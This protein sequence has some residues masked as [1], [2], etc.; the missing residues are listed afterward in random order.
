MATR[1]LALAIS[2]LL[3]ACGGGGSDIAPA[4][5][6][7]PVQVAAYGDS[8]QRDQGEPHA[9]TR[10]GWSI[11]NKG[12]SS[13]TTAQWRAKWAAEMSTTAAVIVIYNGG[14]ND[15]AMPLD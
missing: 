7:A 4:T 6:L 2:A 5:P 13:S 14:L 12:I 15:G 1:I 10:T 8:T 3:T 11:E 9:S